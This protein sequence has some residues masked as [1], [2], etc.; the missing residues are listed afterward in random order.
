MAQIFCSRLR[1]HTQIRMWLETQHTV[2]NRSEIGRFQILKS[3]QRYWDWTLDWED[4]ARA[5]VFS[6]ETGFG[7]DGNPTVKAAAGN[8]YCV[9]NG[10]LADIK[11]KYF[12]LE[13]APHCLSRSFADGGRPPTAGR[14]SGQKYRPK[15]MD[16]L[17]QQQDS[18]SFA[19]KLD[20]IHTAIPIGIRGEM[21]RFTSPYGKRITVLVEQTSQA[22]S[23]LQSQYF[24]SITLK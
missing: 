7:G 4:P 14:L 11:L 16:E 19:A 17:M 6:G 12:G 5:P 20:S 15:A 23:E 10:G 3:S 21:A 2:S 18:T 8:G 9:T 1:E 13:V 22:N 24:S